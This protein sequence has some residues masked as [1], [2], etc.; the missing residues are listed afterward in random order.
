MLEAGSADAGPASGAPP[1][2][3]FPA[4]DPEPPPNP[5]RIARRVLVFAAVLAAGFGGYTAV[6]HLGQS[7]GRAPSASRP[8]AASV[9]AGSHFSG[10]VLAQRPD[11]VL[12]LTDMAS[13]KTVL[14]GKLANFGS[15]TPE[16]I[17]PDGRYLLDPTTGQIVSFARLAHPVAVPNK[18]VFMAEGAGFTQAYWSDHDTSV[19]VLLYQNSVTA[20]FPAVA[21]QTVRTGATAALR[22]IDN[23]AGDPQQPGAFV[24][25]PVPGPAPLNGPPHDAAVE[26]KD[27]GRPARLLATTATLV[28]AV[29]LKKGSLVSLDPIPNP[30]GTMVAIA[31]DGPGGGGI[32]VLSRSGKVV[33]AEQAIPGGLLGPAWSDSGSS[34]AFADEGAQGLELTRW[35]IGGQSVTTIL[36]MSEKSLGSCLWSPDGDSVLCQKGRLQWTLVRS[37]A[38]NSTY[39]FSGDGQ[40]LAWL[41][42]RLG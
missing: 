1:R 23:A 22:G 40:A 32:V 5:W 19:V 42:G 38:A 14:L 27:A 31:V 9:S 8:A 28:R 21:V 17:S 7:S 20:T 6:S 29:G 18:L 15:L 25:V 3:R 26:L 13:G 4:L 39:V 10:V 30:Q 36:N 2:L 34:L 33:A 37:G 35:Q 16:L 12:S 11:G 41:K 24:S